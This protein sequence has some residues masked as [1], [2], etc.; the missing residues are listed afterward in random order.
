[1]Q[2]IQVKLNINK[3]LSISSVHL[4]VSYNKELPGPVC[5]LKGTGSDP[6]SSESEGAE[7]V[8]EYCP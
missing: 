8:E 7:H 6:T 1:M 5:N 2:D 4:P 3:Y